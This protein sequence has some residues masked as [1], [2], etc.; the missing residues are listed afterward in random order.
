MIGLAAA[1]LKAANDKEMSRE[2]HKD[3][4]WLLSQENEIPRREAARKEFMDAA[5]L[6]LDDHPMPRAL[7]LEHV[8][9]GDHGNAEPRCIPC[10]MPESFR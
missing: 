8:L 1:W 4:Q 2:E 10:K 9:A 7:A 3:M 6:Q 5:A